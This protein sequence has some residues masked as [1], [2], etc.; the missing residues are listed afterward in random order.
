MHR[1]RSNSRIALTLVV[2]A[3]PGLAQQEPP[4]SAVR[5]PAATAAAL[6]PPGID[7]APQPPAR[8]EDKVHEHPTTKAGQ[9]SSE[10]RSGASTSMHDMPGMEGM[11][12]EHDRESMVAF[13]GPYSMTREASG[14]SWQPESAPH[15]GLHWSRGPWQL[16]S[17]GYATQVYSDQA[18]RERDTKSF[19][20]NML[21]GMASRQLGAGRLGL[22]VML[23]SEPWTIGR[24]GYP[25]VLQTGETADGVTPLRDR[26]H[27]HD[28]FMELAATYSLPVGGDRSVFLYLGEPGEPAL[29]PPTFIHRF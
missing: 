21:M 12:D 22:R 18:G 8:A 10:H 6:V 23:S 29:G 28:L 7:P 4:P 9:S 25:L 2:L 19:L 20:E 16:M 24:T 13:L 15:D 11:E 27:P 26:Q 14:T 3:R 1:S 17:H 5:E